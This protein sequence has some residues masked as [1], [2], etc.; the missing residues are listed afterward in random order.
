MADELTNPL[1]KEDFNKEWLAR[2]SEL[3]T[4]YSPDLVWF[5]NK[6]DIIGEDY[7]RQFLSD[8]YNLGVKNDQEVVVTYKFHDLRPDAAVIDL[9][10]ARMS[11]AQPFPWLTDDSVDWGTWSHTTTP[12]Y[13][14]A[15]RLI[16]M[17]VDIVSKNG[18]LLLNVPPTAAGEIP[19]PVQDR[20]REMGRWLE[21]NGEA[22]YESR[23]WEIYGEGPTNV[24][25]GHLSERANAD[26]TAE[27]IRFTTRGGYLY[28]IVL[29]WPE[30][31]FLIKSLG[32]Q[33]ILE[34][35]IKTVNLLGHDQP[36]AWEQTDKGLRIEKPATSPKDNAYT[37][38]IELMEPLSK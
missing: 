11:E 17:L 18:C 21:V 36:L 35:E 25:E 8:Y 32:A 16:D 22:I 33:G 38:R 29:D 19:L 4:K 26:N 14:S 6:M 13:K 23:P 15:N 1:P 10:R 5:D 3:T 7:R 30:E 27:D 31:V 24:V 28:A 20:L 2:L 34:Q 12:D 9:E 37:F